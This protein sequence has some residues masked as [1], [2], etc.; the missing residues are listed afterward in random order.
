[1]RNSTFRWRRSRQFRRLIQRHSLVGVVSGRP[2]GLEMRLSKNRD[3]G[4]LDQ[5]RDVV[6]P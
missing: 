2:T 1:M 3:A 4:R 6:G 5:P